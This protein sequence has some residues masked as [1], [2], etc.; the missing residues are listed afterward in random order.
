MSERGGFAE[1]DDKT[2]AAL[3]DK[4][5]REYVRTQLEDFREKS[6]RFVY[7][8]RRLAETSRRIVLDTA[9]ELRRSDFRPLDFELNFSNKDD[10]DLPPVSVGSGEDEFVLTGT[11]DRVDGWEHGG[12]LYIRIV[13]Y[14]SGK[15]KFALSDVW[16]GMGLQMLLYLFT[17]EKHGAERY[18]KEIVPAGVLYVPAHD[19]LVRADKRLSDEEIVAEKARKLHRSGLILSE[20]EVVEAMEGTAKRCNSF[21]CTAASSPRKRSPRPSQLGKLS[22]FLEETL[23][24]MAGELRGGSIAADPWYENDRANTCRT[25]DYCDACRFSETA[26]GWRFKTKFKAPEFWEKLENG[27]EETA[28][29]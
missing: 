17:L 14:K 2:V 8:F 24:N 29:P 3:T 6:P 18:G 13:D 23:S 20:T 21:R 10:A 5:V 7:L 25:C 15:K 28:C 19:I 12:K 1:T 9:Q 16:Q 22:R 26:D 27:E 11:A 4:Y